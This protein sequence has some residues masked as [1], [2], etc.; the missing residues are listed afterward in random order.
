MKLLKIVLPILLITGACKKDDGETDGIACP[1][2]PVLVPVTVLDTDGNPLDANVEI[3]TVN[4][5][6]PDGQD[7][8]EPRTV[9]TPCEGGNGSYTCEAYPGDEINQIS[10]TLFPSYQAAAARA[11]VDGEDCESVEIELRM[12]PAQK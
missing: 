1:V 8:T 12:I 6:N 11:L 4:P 3:S 10:A 9:D 5:N 2:S 7:P